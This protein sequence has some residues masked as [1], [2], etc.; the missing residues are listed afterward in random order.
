MKTVIC[1]M[2][3]EDLDYHTDEDGN[4]LFFDRF[5]ELS[6]YLLDN[7]IDTNSVSVFDVE[8]IDNE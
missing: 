6:S 1:F 2:L 5:D 4:I 3:P 7:N 8:V